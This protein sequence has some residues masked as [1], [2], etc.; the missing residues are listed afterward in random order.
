MEEVQKLTPSTKTV[1]SLIDTYQSLRGSFDPA[2]V[3]PQL[4]CFSN[5]IFEVVEDL[6]KALEKALE[7]GPLESLVELHNVILEGLTVCVNHNQKAKIKLEAFEKRKQAFQ[8]DYNS[9][10]QATQEDMPEAIVALCKKYPR[11]FH[12]YLENNTEAFNAH[13]QKNPRTCLT[14]GILFHAFDTCKYRAMYYIFLAAM[15]HNDRHAQEKIKKHATAFDKWL[16]SPLATTFL[17][18]DQ[19]NDYTN[20]LDN[21]RNEMEREN[22]FFGASIGKPLFFEPQDTSNS[23]PSSEYIEMECFFTK[24]TKIG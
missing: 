10:T 14:L 1:R 8:N 17:E 2:V 9:A 13:I 18:Q 6:E 11:E 12:L 23:L 19:I 7:F 15:E 21:L 4:L 5:L 20:F 22:S 16:K 24:P 3:E